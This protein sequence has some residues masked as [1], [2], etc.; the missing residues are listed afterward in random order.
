MEIAGK[1]AVV[2]GAG[3][4]IGRA[5]ALALAAA[6]AD[7]ALAD[8]DEAAMARVAA[9]IRALGRRCLTALV[10]VA[11]AEQVEALAERT[12]KELGAAH[13]LVNNAGV[14]AGGF[15]HEIPLED[16]RWSMG[17]NLWGPI[18]GTR[19]FVPRMIAKGEG[20]HIVNI[21]SV[22]GLVG[23]PLLGPYC[24]AK[25][26]LVALSECTRAELAAERIG[27]SVLCPG[28]VATEIFNKARSTK[29]E[30]TPG[31]LER[32]GIPPERVAR[33]VLRAIR[34]DRLY[35]LTHL[36]MHAAWLLKRFSPALM[37]RLVRWVAGSRVAKASL[38]AT[39]VP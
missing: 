30:M 28:F 10:D 22:A 9:E 20:G 21:A 15:A 18:H 23:V 33:K 36:S 16:W 2:T 35:V 6:G 34:G 39:R 4:G 11:S 17:V 8:I 1:V 7:L 24:M 26:A 25:S 19:S 14:G 32:H 12:V 5:T 3:G 13:I 29:I 31:F 38:G 27:V 37:N